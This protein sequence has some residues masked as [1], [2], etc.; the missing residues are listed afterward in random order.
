MVKKLLY[1]ICKWT[2]GFYL[3]RRFTRQGLR[4][5]AYH[6]FALGDEIDFQ[7]LLFMDT[8]VFRERMNYLLRQGYPVLSLD[9]AVE[10][11]QAGNLPD[12]A[13]T[14]TFDDGF[15]SIWKMAVPVLNDLKLPATIY[16]TTYYC[17]KGN[18]IFRLVI[19]Y[20][21]WKTTTTELDLNDLGLPEPGKVHFPDAESLNELA[22]RIIRYAESEMDE[23]QRVRLCE[24][25]GKRLNVNY[26]AIVKN[27]FFTLMTKEEIREASRAGV[28]IQLHTHRHA[29]PTEAK[30]IAKEIEDNRE[31][32][33]PLV[34]RRLHHFCYPS[35]IHHK[36]HLHSLR[37]AEVKS[38]TTCQA[39]LNYSD[40]PPLTLN[41]FLDGNNVSW[42][43][44]EAEMSGFSDLLRKARY[45]LTQFIHHGGDGL[46]AW[47]MLACFV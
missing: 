44:F 19:Q 30:L 32:L 7:P 31:L 29:L 43:E 11:L 18:P 21:F 27:R 1:H 38:G 24:E 46:A 8:S 40:A 13:T 37:E 14:L 9:D 16:V 47:G 17:L 15:H 33:E 5:L 26:S 42:I 39:G 20:M 45:R 35:G 25:L 36:D 28:D 41:R 22:W 10:R 4:I 3:A 12:C 6:G 23:E 34:G 2:G